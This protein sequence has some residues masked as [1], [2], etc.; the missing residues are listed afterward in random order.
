MK[1]YL[2]LISCML[3]VIFAFSACGSSKT[4]QQTVE[5]MLNCI[6][7]LDF[8][9]AK[10]YLLNEDLGIDKEKLS[11]LGKEGDII[12]SLIKNM[13]Y[14][15]ISVENVD[16]NTKIV[17][18]KLETFNVKA[19]MSDFVPVVLSHTIDSMQVLGNGEKA[20]PGK[21]ITA[22]FNELMNDE[23]YL[24][25]EKVVDIKV[26][27]VSGS[28]KIDIGESLIRFLYKDVNEMFDQLE[29]ELKRIQVNIND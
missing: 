2:K 6:Q 5:Q 21:L 14:Q 12:K 25:S 28:W 23:K 17:H 9:K 4:P 3:I 24:N 7:K 15:V 16:E 20:D 29:E 26:I 11:S 22:D 1:K 19:L 13:S 10:G 18:V 27:N 8:D